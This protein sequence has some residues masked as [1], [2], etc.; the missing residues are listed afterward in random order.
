MKQKF[1]R[2]TIWTDETMWKKTAIESGLTY[3]V[4]DNKINDCVSKDICGICVSRQEAL[5][6]AEKLNNTLE[7]PFDYEKN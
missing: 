3:G 4:Y 2:Y 5:D 7:D 1:K 6:A